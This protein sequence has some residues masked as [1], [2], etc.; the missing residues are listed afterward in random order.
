MSAKQK[1]RLLSLEYTEQRATKELL[2]EY[3]MLEANLP[4]FVIDGD[5]M[6]YPAAMRR[7]KNA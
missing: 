7:V 3:G 4:V 1:L 6:E 2:L 5:A